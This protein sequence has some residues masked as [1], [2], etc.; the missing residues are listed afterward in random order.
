VIHAARIA[1]HELVGRQ[2][3]LASIEE[4][5]AAGALAPHG[6]GTMFLSGMPGIGKSRLAREAS[7]RAEAAG[8]RTAHVRCAPDRS[9]LRPLQELVFDVVRDSSQSDDA[10]VEQLLPTLRSLTSDA[11]EHHADDLSILVLA[12]SLLRAL[13]AARAGQPLLVVFEDV[14][15]AAPET[16]AVLEHLVDHGPAHGITLLATLRPEPAPSADLVVNAVARRAARLIDLAPLSRD[17]TG[18]LASLCLDGGPL[19][20]ELLSSLYERA[21]GVPFLVEEVLA[22]ALADGRV[23]RVNAEWACPRGLGDLLPGTVGRLML[24]RAGAAGDDV[25]RVLDAAAVLGRDFE[26]GTLEAVACL[27][28]DRVTAALRAAM[29]ALLLEIGHDGRMRFRH[30][31]TR[32]AFLTELLP[33]QRRTLARR[34]L[35]AMTALPRGEADLLTAARLAEDAGENAAAADLLCRAAC[36]HLTRGALHSA[37][38][39]AR[40]GIALVCEDPAGRVD[41]DEV[42]LAVL[43]AAGKTEAAAAVGQEALVLLDGL[44]APPARTAAVHVMLARNAVTAGAYRDATDH[45][46]AARRLQPGGAIAARADVQLAEAAL[47][48]GNAAAAER[49]AATAIAA[50]ADDLELLCSALDVQGRA[51]RVTDFGG[52]RAIFEQLLGKATAHG[53]SLWRARALLH[54]GALDM[55]STGRLDRLEEAS[56]AAERAGAMGTAAEIEIQ[57]VLILATQ[58]RL[59]E[60]LDVAQRVCDRAERYRLG[61]LPMAVVCQGGIRGWMGDRAGMERFATQALDLAGDDPSIAALCWGDLRGMSSLFADDRGR[62]L[63]CFERAMAYEPRPLT[64][65]APFRGMWALL[66]TIDDNEGALAREVVRETAAHESWWVLAW[67]RYAD[68]V[69]LGRSAE[70]ADADACAAVADEIIDGHHAAGWAKHLARRFLAEAALADGWGDPVRWLRE[71]AAFFDQSHPRLASSCRGRLRTAGVR[72]PRRGRGTAAVPDRCRAM[73]VTSR[74][75]DVLLLIG[76]GLTNRDIAERLFLSP[77]TVEKHVQTLYQKTASTSR[78]QLAVLAATLDG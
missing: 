36:D 62:A 32:D 7:A 63:A 59:A 12:E 64:S 45:A 10:Q 54:L 67:L 27:D 9:A 46:Q 41:L 71:A 13:D 5:L 47:A 2:Q 65:P 56:A 35:T 19:S 68:A 73:G 38:D 6:G 42:L 16:I 51:V 29:D 18:H 3:E 14:H 74:E 52:G 55:L 48:A 78:T 31:L 37:E 75:M 25:R 60:A 15:W 22:A 1:K 33:S 40:R 66:R 17:E 57:T 11:A 49:L 50:A 44:A 61:M 53:L 58:F 24:S 20:A 8:F 76:T 34:A 30:A 70:R 72:V 39:A 77:R 23:H 28:A 43:C 4:V 21:D 69:A 26:T